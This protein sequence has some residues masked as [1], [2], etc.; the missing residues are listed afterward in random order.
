L[1]FSIFTFYGFGDGGI[2]L[3]RMNGSDIEK[4]ADVRGEDGEEIIHIFGPVR[5]IDTHLTKIDL[6]GFPVCD[7]RNWSEEEIFEPMQG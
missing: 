7:K 2:E 6:I 4:D 1:E 5:L 3:E